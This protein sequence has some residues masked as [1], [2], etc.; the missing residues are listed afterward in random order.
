V[1]SAL[2]EAGVILAD[3]SAW[4]EF[5]RGTGSRSCRR[6]DELLGAGLATT[7]V[8]EMEVLAGAR[9]D[10]HLERLRRLLLRAGPR[11]VQTGDFDAAAGLYRACRRRGET[12]P[13]L[14]DCL[15]AAVAIRND[16]PVLHADTDFE[17]IARH[18]SLRLDETHMP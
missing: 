3:T 7:E 6:V 5:L 11:R 1:A 18:S 9:D 4:V 14:A 13:S 12:P 2:V 10:H 16:V 8:V 17:V 15:I